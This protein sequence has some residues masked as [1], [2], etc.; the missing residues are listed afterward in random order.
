MLITLQIG[1]ATLLRSH[2]SL[3][4][5]GS[6]GASPSHF[7]TEKLA[8]R[9]ASRL[10]PR[11]E[12][13]MDK[14]TVWC[15]IAALLLCGGWMAWAQDA[16]DAP[17]DDAVTRTSSSVQDEATASDGR[18]GPS[19]GG[20]SNE[21]QWSLL[22]LA[23]GIVI[24]LGLIIGFK[25]NA[26]VALITAA[27][28]VSLLA[29]GAWSG[30]ISRVADAF[31]SAAGGIGIVIAMAA[32]IGK[33]MLDS[34][35][36]DRIVRAFLHLLGEK[37]APMALMGSGFV[38][39]VPV[40]FDTVFYLLV[41]LARSFYRRTN[42]DYLKYILAIGA[43]GAITHTLVPPTP[44]PLLMAENLG[45]Q[46]GMMIMIG[47][48]VALPAA[49]VGLVFASV[50]N[51][52]MPVP[53]RQVAGQ[54]DP[55]PLKDEELPSLLMS[56]LP[57]V[58]PV[59][60]ISANTVLSLF[61]DAEH[62]A[63]FSVSDIQDWPAWRQEIADQAAQKSPTPGGRVM[64]V[65]NEAQASISKR[66]DALAAGPAKEKVA[67][68]LKQIDDA[69]AALTQSPATT[70]EQ[71][72]AIVAMLNQYVLGDKAFYDEEAFLGVRINSTAKNLLGKNRVRMNKVNVERMNRSL[73][74]SAYNL[75]GPQLS[76]EDRVQGQ[77]IIPHTWGTP[78]RQYA[79][80]SQIFGNANFAL[81]L[82]A[83]IAMITLVRQRGLS[84]N[85]LGHATEIAL[86]SG[87]VIILITAGGGAFGK[88]LEAANVGD[89]IK[90]LF[91]ISDEGGGGLMFLVLG[92]AI[93]AVLKVAQGSSTVAMI[94]GSSML[95]GI[96]QPELLG[97]HP[98][99]LATAIGG[100]SLVGSWMND[101]GFWIFAKMGG[102]TETE[103]LKSWTIMLV[104]LGFVSFGLSVLLATVLPLV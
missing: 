76:D 46:I 63:L 75:S 96:A 84:W 6:A 48:L 61:A 39:A 36:A 5:G 97:F 41:P 13:L 82:S 70:D 98:V 95:A 8:Q 9:Q 4:L 64:Q 66:H 35:A 17:P 103:A 30:K 53:M 49:I 77:F 29:P 78:L 60:L 3:T 72:E 57:V 80:Y 83:V 45:F 86:M 104:F 19:H 11:W 87:G 42:K 20:L 59:V 91:S 92:F 47:S 68:Q 24:V 62:A 34:G 56:L 16:A 58:L 51:R 1:N 28:V 89:A 43:G 33:C 65:L 22:V 99:Y 50:M 27:I 67:A 79:D 21:H 12:C 32:I 23:I 26:F 37:R 52:L 90:A 10:P 93:A 55:E 7:N 85:E 44:G 54:P 73:L 94:I 81:L 2:A 40:F 31:G 38:L 25:I 101:S 100:G 14:R 74:E 71:R 69:L 88:M 15:G 18:G 102:L